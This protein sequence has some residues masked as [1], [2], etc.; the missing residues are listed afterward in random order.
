M[1]TPPLYDEVREQ[2]D[3]DDSESDAENLSPSPITFEE[4]R[5]ARGEV[6]IYIS[7]LR[8]D[9]IDSLNLKYTE[10]DVENS[11]LTVCLQRQRL[12]FLSEKSRFTTAKQIILS[13]RLFP[14]LFPAAALEAHH[15]AHANAYIN[16]YIHFNNIRRIGAS[17]RNL[18]IAMNQIVSKSSLIA[19]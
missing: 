4:Q 19:A 2:F 14:A 18:K 3:S 1:D 17:L 10:L 16:I 15:E 11:R 13:S 8:D 5:R 7:S 9:T 6:N 12:F